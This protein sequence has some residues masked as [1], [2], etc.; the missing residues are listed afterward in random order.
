MMMMMMIMADNGFEE[1][2]MMMIMADYEKAYCS[3]WMMTAVVNFWATG[4]Y[5]FSE[6]CGALEIMSVF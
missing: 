3:P 1:E 6:F 2:L 4:T 5:M